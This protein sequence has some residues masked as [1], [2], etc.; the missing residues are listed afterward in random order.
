MHRRSMPTRRRIKD[1]K[2]EEGTRVVR[3]L[4]RHVK[5]TNRSGLA[6]FRIP[7]G[8]RVGPSVC[9]KSGTSVIAPLSASPFTLGEKERQRER[10]S[11]CTEGPVAGP[12]TPCNCSSCSARTVHPH[13]L[14]R[15]PV[16]D[17]TRCAALAVPPIMGH[18]WVRIAG[19]RG[20]SNLPRTVW[21]RGTEWKR[22]FARSASVPAGKNKT[23]TFMYLLLTFFILVLWSLNDDEIQNRILF[24]ILRIFFKIYT[25]VCI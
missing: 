12:A 18:A 8:H 11:V 25:C 23:W 5:L 10:E 6:S 1:E 15:N 13:T 24:I 7:R 19:V 3:A 9:A 14:P 2:C 17:N 22:K 20:P 4:V 16:F 21:D